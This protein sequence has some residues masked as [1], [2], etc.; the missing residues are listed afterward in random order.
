[1]LDIEPS[2]NREQLG[3][4]ADRLLLGVRPHASAGKARF[5]LP[6]EPGGYGYDIDGLEG[7]ARTFLMAGFRLAGNKGHDPLGLAEWY[8]EGIATGTDPNS[9]ERWVRLSEHGQAKVEAASTALILDMTR[10]WIWDKLDSTVQRNVITYLAEAVGDDTYPP[11]NWLWFRLVVET[12]LRSVDGPHLMSDMKAD[13]ALHD[14]FLRSDGWMSDGAQ[15]NYD[16][17]VGWALNL[18]PVLWARMQGAEDLAAPRRDRDEEMLDRYLV[19]AVRMVGADGAPMI[20]GRSLIY[21]FAAAAPFWVGALAEVP[22]TPLGQLRRAGSKIVQHFHDRDVPGDDDLLTMG[23]Y[24]EWRTMAQSY[25]GTGSPYWASKGLLGLALPEEH[26]VWTAPEVALPTETSDDLFT[27]QPAGWVI[28]TTTADGI[29]RIINH[30]TDHT[31]PGST[32]GDSPLYGRFGYSTATAPLLDPEAWAE[33]LD[34][35]VVLLDADGHATH[36][37]GMD[38]L[39]TRVEQTPGGPM[40]VAASRSRAHWVVPEAGQFAHGTGYVGDVTD[41]G[42]VA[43]ISLVRGSWELRLARV[44]AAAEVAVA[45]RVS[46][47][48]VVG[49]LTEDGPEG[50]AEALDGS[51]T[52]RI[53]PVGTARLAVEQRDDASPM[54]SPVHI[55]TATF[56]VDP[57]RWVGGLIELTGQAAPVVA[58]SVKAVTAPLGTTVTVTWPDGLKTSTFIRVTGPT[59]GRDTNEGDTE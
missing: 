38:L 7:F 15:R 19:D 59:T 31:L 40:G 26:P 35:A 51:L 24:H 21:R 53:I 58:C 52:S 32:A 27:V 25:S 4:Y 43:S 11:I 45:L 55:P 34:S 1:M 10:P 37:A 17:Y 39:E 46:G 50:V 14:S 5:Q 22:S 18:Y 33:P 41:A 56:D 12:F 30:G 44:E 16:H 2:W 42:T 48:P 9:P 29:S 57:S 23:W 13:L 6:G 49:P 36:R 3:A 28:S 54:G 47:W 8:A 20:Q